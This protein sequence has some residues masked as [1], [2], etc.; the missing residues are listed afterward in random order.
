MN[1]GIILINYNNSTDTIQCIKSIIRSVEL[2][3]LIDNVIICVI[4]NSSISSEYYRIKQAINYKNF[5]IKKMKN[6]GYGAGINKAV[7]LIHMLCDNFFFLGND[8]LV[9]ENFIQTIFQLF[10]SDKNTSIFGIKMYLY[11]ETDR[12][13]SAGGV[14]S[15]FGYA[16]DICLNRK[17]EDCEFAN[18]EYE[19]F[20]INGGSLGIRK[21][22]FFELGGFDENLFLYWEDVDLC[23]RARLKNFKIKYSPETWVYHKFHGSQG[24]DMTPRRLVLARFGAFYVLTKNLST[25]NLLFRLCGLFS[26]TFFSIIIK[27]IL[28]KD[29][30]YFKVYFQVIYKYLKMLTRCLKERKIVQKSRTV[31]DKKILQYDSIIPFKQ[32]F[33]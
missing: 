20:Y 5:I 21:E 24:R 16:N 32:I 18:R 25:L 1:I 26:L 27:P 2:A 29:I 6:K 15:F 22:V 10:V 33:Q 12:I 17:E 28:E 8:T 11:P 13:Q 9:P 3:G 19:P 31:R 7:Q 23:W 4:D 30:S 14:I